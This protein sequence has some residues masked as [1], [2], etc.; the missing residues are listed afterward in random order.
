MPEQA[1]LDVL[2]TYKLFIDGKF[3]RTE[4]GRTMIVHDRSGGVLAHACKGSR[5]DL[6]EAVEAARKAQPGWA[7]ATAYL[8]GQIIY[9]IAEM[10]EGRRAEFVQTIASVDAGGAA[11]AK[12]T[13][14]PA[15]GGAA[16]AEAEVTAAVDRL[17]AFAGWADKFAQVLGCNNPV[18]GPYYNFTVPEASGVVAV[19]CPDEMPLL[20]LVS[21]VAPV[22]CA[23]NA[24]V[25]IASQ[26]N[27][28]PGAILGEVLATGDLPGGVVNIL[29]GERKELLPF[30]SGHRDIDAVH[31]A[32][33]S[34]E[35]TT[36]L[37]EG[38]AENVKRVC[39][40]ETVAWFDAAECHSPWW[41]EPFVD[42]KTM[43]HPASV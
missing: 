13:S 42:M 34:R 27:P 12:K 8:R 17:V 41:I 38:S 33:L 21:L 16:A 43:W 19:V 31:A 23:G 18:A 26:A 6:R 10:L 2:K 15:R 22:I 11:G 4:S 29:T 14:K 9:R 37:R 36:I 28:L 35:E 5:K 7:G 24:A 40:R 1:R 32:C 20:G 3:P 25:V 39:V 30:V